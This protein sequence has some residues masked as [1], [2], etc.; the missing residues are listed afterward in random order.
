MKGLGLGLGRKG[1]TTWSFPFLFHTVGSMG[2]RAQQVLASPVT[3]PTT[4]PKG[5][6]VVKPAAAK[7]VAKKKKDKAA[8]TSFEK[9][10][11]KKVND[12]AV[13]RLFQRGLVSS[14]AK[15]KINA[16]MRRLIHQRM[17]EDLKGILAMTSVARK[18]TIERSHV[19]AYYAMQGRRLYGF[20]QN[21]QRKLAPAAKTE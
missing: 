14:L 12:S 11:K 4:I 13:R 8:P 20:P 17:K 18:K 9:D 19:L 15:E 5:G 2:K 21:K 10:M 7:A 6:K 16:F 1:A 3:V